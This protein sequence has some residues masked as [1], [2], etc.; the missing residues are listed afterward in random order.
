MKKQTL[1]RILILWLLTLMVCQNA[2]F[3]ADRSIQYFVSQ[4]E[5]WKKLIGVSQTLEGRI[6]TFSSKSL[7]FRNCPIPFYF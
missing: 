7:R 4:R 2:V 3:S 5:Q 6:S 1:N